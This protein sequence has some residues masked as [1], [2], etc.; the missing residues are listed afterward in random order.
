M[1][2]Q[3]MFLALLPGILIV[4]IVYRQDRVEKEPKS[5]IF[6]LILFGALSCIPAIFMETFMDGMMPNA[7]RSGGLGYA[8][9]NAFLSAALCE[10]LCKYFLLKLGSWRNKNFDYRFDAILYAVSV[11]VGFALLENILY[12]AD[13]GI[14]TALMRG[15]LSVPLHAFCGVFMGIYYGEAKMLKIQG[16]F[17]GI[18]KLKA[19]LIPMLI[20]G[21]YDTLA[22]LGTGASTIGLLAFVVVLYI[23][24]IRAIR[25]YS[26]DDWKNGLYQQPL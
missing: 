26:I 6:K 5:L 2:S 21:I 7:F 25:R 12:V 8:M 14:Q 24:S 9:W 11:A 15:V 20:H 10:E 17:A 18:A 16:K 19:L 13:G 4:F 1:S 3:L 23:I 22:F